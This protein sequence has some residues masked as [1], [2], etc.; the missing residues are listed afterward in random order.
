MKPVSFKT[1]AKITSMQSPQ[2]AALIEF[3]SARTVLRPGDLI[4]TGTRQEW[5]RRASRWSSW[6]QATS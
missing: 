2:R 1:K 4:F 3:I 5:V 6:P